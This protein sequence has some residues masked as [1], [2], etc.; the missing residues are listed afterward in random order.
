MFHVLE[1]SMDSILWLRDEVQRQVK[2]VDK[3]TGFP[4]KSVSWNSAI[5]GDSV[6]LWIKLQMKHCNNEV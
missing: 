6:E 4:T 2:Q 5:C 3:T 1:D